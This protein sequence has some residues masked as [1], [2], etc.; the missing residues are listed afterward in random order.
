[1]KN[2]SKILHEQK[3]QFEE[4]M[5]IFQNDIKSSPNIKLDELI[6]IL[7]KEIENKLEN[8]IEVIIDKILINYLEDNKRLTN[9]HKEKDV[10]HEVYYKLCHEQLTSFKKKIIQENLGKQDYLDIFKIERNGFLKTELIIK[11]SLIKELINKLQQNENND[12]LYYLMKLFQIDGMKQIS[13]YILKKS[14]GQEKINIEDIK[15]LNHILNA[16]FI[17]EILQTN[18][19]KNIDELSE[20]ISNFT[21]GNDYPLEKEYIQ[22]T[23][24]Y[25]QQNYNLK[26]PVINPFDF[27]YLFINFDNEGNLTKGFI[28]KEN[29]SLDIYKTI[30]AIEN[31]NKDSLNYQ[32]CYNEIINI[33]QNQDFYY[34]DIFG[35]FIQRLSNN[36]SLEFHFNDIDFNIGKF[37]FL[38]NERI[39]NKYPSL[40]YYLIENPNEEYLQFNQNKTLIPFWLYNLILECPIN[41]IQIHGIEDSDFN[42]IINKLIQQKKKIKNNEE[43]GIDWLS[44]IYC[45]VLYKYKNFFLSDFYKFLI[46]ILKDKELKINLNKKK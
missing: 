6:I 8:N 42:S 22:K 7:N 21:F 31:K 37:Q 30:K 2:Y 1:M 12:M 34:K 3:I 17:F 23:K 35:K 36:F 13:E 15:L 24:K 10:E 44:L 46:T 38:E 5:N 41:I 20:F 25:F 18:N 45:N 9:F 33:F 4:K 11:Y 26:I 29:L 32:E 39:Y 40:V 14:F 27:I 19:E 28:L 16:K 43:I